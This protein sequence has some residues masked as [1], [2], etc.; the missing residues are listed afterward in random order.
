MI[1][2]LSPSKTL[3]L[4]QTISAE[5][6]TTPYFHNEANI[7]MKDLSKISVKDLEKSM[8]L[9]TELAQTVRGWHKSWGETLY[10]CGTAMKGEAF[11][12]LDYQTLSNK[13]TKYSIGRFY[14]LSG[15]YGALGGTDGIS[16]YR[17]EMA[18]KFKPYDGSR[19][20]NE[21]WAKRLPEFFN[22]ISSVSD[23][24][25]LANLA[26][27]EY[28]KVVIRPELNLDVIDFDFKIETENGLKNISV[29][30]KQAR[31]AMAR[32]ILENRIEN[33]EELK[34]FEVLGYRFR[35]EL[36]STNKLTYTRSR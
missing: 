12:A 5:A 30:A 28:N 16:P 11:K 10:Q 32:Y 15:L 3:D 1:I 14:V 21:F 4:G 2:I 19:S 27:D 25:Y 6:L 8:K 24:N 29:F 18:Q 33:I 9:S 7:L 36:S 35:K 31:G 26:S 20:L 22:N 13:I 17:L 34:G 23:I